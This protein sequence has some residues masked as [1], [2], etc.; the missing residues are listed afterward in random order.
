MNESESKKK[1]LGSSC[2]ELVSKKKDLGSSCCELV[3]MTHRP[4][5]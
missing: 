5:C 4:V 1:D 3:S 2:C